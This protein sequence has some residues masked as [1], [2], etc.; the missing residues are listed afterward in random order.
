M[1]LTYSSIMITFYM[2]LCTGNSYFSSFTLPWPSS[3][4]PHRGVKGV[5]ALP[6]TWMIKV[7]QMIEKSEVSS[8]LDAVPSQMF[9]WT[10]FR[11]IESRSSET[12]DLHAAPP[13]RL[14]QAQ[15]TLPCYCSRL[16]LLLVVLTARGRL[17]CSD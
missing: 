16:L 4:V 17:Y 7:G 9:G 5:K 14:T 15:S 12:E 11:D 10:L 1:F 6:L 8:L 2:I 13:M 3:I